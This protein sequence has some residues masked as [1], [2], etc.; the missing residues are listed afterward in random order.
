MMK[1]DDYKLSITKGREIKRKIPVL[2]IT[3]IIHISIGPTIATTTLPPGIK[4]K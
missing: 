2:I 1:T 4:C 3:K